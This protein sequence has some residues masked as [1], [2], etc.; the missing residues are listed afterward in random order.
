MLR[1]ILLM[2][3]I[4]LFLLFFSIINILTRDDIVSRLKKYIKENRVNKQNKADIPKDIRNMFGFIIKGIKKARFLNGYKNNIQYKITRANMMLKPEEFIAIRITLFI[5]SAVS[6]YLLQ[7]S[8]LVV[9][10]F[11]IAGWMIPGCIL[12]Y[13]VKKRIK[14][15]DEQLGD[16]IKLISNS[17]KAGYSFFQSIG[18]VVD[19]MNGPVAE[20]FTMVQKEI[21]L[22]ITTE[23]ALSN[24]AERIGSEDL[25]LIITAVL[26]QRNIG[27]NLAEVLE[28]IFSTIRERV[29]LT[30][31]VKAITAQGRISGL[32]ISLLP[33]VLGVL[34]FFINPEHMILLF[35]DPIGIA[36][37]VFSILMQLAGIYFVRKIVNIKI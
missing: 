29:K 9:L 20:E 21:N 33:I 17:L 2:T 12:N 8:V 11:T 13:N 30:G 19:E 27:G 22:G 36:I 26:I 10:L 1:L 31:E 7:C 37:L 35:T 28:S 4:S 24:L 14:R 15:I 25:E 23:K 34:L 16:T 3:F 5:L 32:I 18:I 6:G